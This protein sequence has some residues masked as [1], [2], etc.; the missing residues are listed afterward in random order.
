MA[1]TVHF[2]KGC[3]WADGH[4]QQSDT[5]QTTNWYA[6]TCKHCRNNSRNRPTPIVLNKKQKK[7][8]DKITREVIKEVTGKSYD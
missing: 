7:E 5:I 6:V 3:P 8:F 1:K 2:V 4:I